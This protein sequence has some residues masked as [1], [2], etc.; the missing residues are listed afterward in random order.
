MSGHGCPE[1]RGRWHHHGYVMVP[2]LRYSNYHVVIVPSPKDRRG[3]QQQH[4][5]LLHEE[6]NHGYRIDLEKSDSR[7]QKDSWIEGGDDR[8]VLCVLDPAPTA[9]SPF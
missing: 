3:S 8:L 6:W 7:H 9:S 1:G 5:F 2:A 4:R